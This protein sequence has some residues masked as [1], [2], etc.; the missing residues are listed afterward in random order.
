MGEIVRLWLHLLG[1]A[2]WVGSQVFV[3]AVVVP[4]LHTLDD[5]QARLKAVRVMTRNFGWLGW[6][7][8]LGQ[9]ATG[10]WLLGSVEFDYREF[11]YGRVL[12][13]KLL[14]V[15]LTVGLTALHTFILGP[16]MLRLMGDGSQPLTADEETKLLKLRKQSGIISAVTLLLAILIIGGAATLTSTWA[17]QPV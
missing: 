15:M 12:D 4:M 2:V 8:L 13:A 9:V 14:L 7:A 3:F 5:R 11:R 17:R 1:A 16:R 6:A 10:F